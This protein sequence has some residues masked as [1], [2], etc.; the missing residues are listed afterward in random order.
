VNT[1]RLQ[2]I[3]HVP[4]GWSADDLLAHVVG[5]V[6]AVTIVDR[7][8]TDS[9]GAGGQPQ[10]VSVVFQGLNDNEARET[11]R[12]A[13]AGLQASHDVLLDRKSGQK[14]ERVTR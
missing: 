4:A 2:V 6:S 8:R 3:A 1:Y 9:L 10:R 7:A 12:R 13:V 5:G 14:F 11:T